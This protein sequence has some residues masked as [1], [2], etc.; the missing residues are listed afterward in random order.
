MAKQNNAQKVPRSSS[1][2]SGAWQCKREAKTGK[3]VSVKVA[4]KTSKGVVKES[5]SKRSAALIRL[6]DR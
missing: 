1:P 2:K 3:F 6:A 5:A 4:S